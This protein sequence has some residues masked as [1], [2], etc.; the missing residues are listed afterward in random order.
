MSVQARGLVRS[1]WARRVARDILLSWL[2]IFLLWNLSSSMP[3]LHFTRLLGCRWSEHDID[4]SSL[5]AT[6]RAQVATF[7][8]VAERVKGAAEV[9]LPRLRVDVVLAE[10]AGVN[11]PLP[12]D[13]GVCTLVPATP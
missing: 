10:L 8:D 5:T 3:V 9:R 13:G 7:A 11:C 12:E 2:H 1:V 6:A 4:P